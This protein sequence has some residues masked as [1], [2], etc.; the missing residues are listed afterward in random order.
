MYVF[1]FLPSSFDFIKRYGP[2]TMAE[3][4]I[5]RPIKLNGQPNKTNQTERPQGYT[6]PSPIPTDSGNACVEEAE[7]HH[8][9]R[10]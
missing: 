5:H 7:A 10:S 6:G 9:W 8:V 2:S 4:Q 1:F 3:A